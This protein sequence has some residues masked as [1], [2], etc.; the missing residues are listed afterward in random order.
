MAGAARPPITIQ[1]F[2]PTAENWRAP[3]SQFSGRG[4]REKLAS[5]LRF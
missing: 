2:N 1:V 4:E 5:L 3:A